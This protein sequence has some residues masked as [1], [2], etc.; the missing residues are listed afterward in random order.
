MPKF[1]KKIRDHNSKGFSLIEIMIA[2]TFLGIGLLAVAQMIPAGMAGVTQAQLRTRAVQAAQ[3]KVDELR[4]QTFTSPTLTPG[5]Y[6]ETS[7]NFTLDWTITDNDP[8]P[9]MKRLDLTSSWQHYTGT[10]TVTLNT[11]ITVGQ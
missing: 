8:I 11:Y 9:G 7:G 1:L 3:E 4:V 5:T 6:S 10:K 2:M